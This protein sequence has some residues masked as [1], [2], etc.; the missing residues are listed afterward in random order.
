MHFT[1]FQIIAS[2]L[3]R[4]HSDISIKAICQQLNNVM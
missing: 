3:F 4:D 1:A 2:N